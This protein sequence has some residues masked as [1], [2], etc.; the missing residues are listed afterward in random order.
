MSPLFTNTL[1]VLSKSCEYPGWP[2][3]R[4]CLLSGPATPS[5]MGVGGG[6]DGPKRSIHQHLF[7]RDFQG[8]KVP[9]LPLTLSLCSIT[10]GGQKGKKKRGA[11]L[12][13]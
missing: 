6:N 8:H 7:L 10:F 4:D 1:M 3:L 12:L 9:K 11:A 13:C 2:L 5:G